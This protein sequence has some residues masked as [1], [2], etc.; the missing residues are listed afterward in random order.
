MRRL[1]STR[2]RLAARIGGAAAGA[3]TLLAPLHAFAGSALENLQAA[4]KATGTTALG[5]E[6]ETDLPTLV[7]RF[8]AAALGLLGVILVILII[9]AGFLWMT[10]Q[11]N[12]EKVKKAKGMITNAVVGM[13]LIFAAYAI[14]TF[15]VDSLISASAS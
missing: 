2:Q 10:A 6:T 14:T 9:Y 5:Q 8:I 11:G 7:G 4:A 12:E 1:T 13:I 15:V 3:A